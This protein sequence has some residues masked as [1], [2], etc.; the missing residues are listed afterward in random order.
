MRFRHALLL[1]LFILLVDQ[2]LK[3]YIKTHYFLGQEHLITNWF[4]LH[5][6]ENEGMAYGWKLGGEWGKLAL[7]LFRLVAV[8]FGTFY[9]RYIIRRSYHF[10]FVICATLIYA[11]AIGNLID[12]LFYG[13][14]F[15]NSDPF[16]QNVAHSFMDKGFTGGYAGFLHGKVVD[17]LY[18][19]IITD[20]TIPKW[21][22]V[23]GGE[24]F[25]FFRP[26]FNIADASISIGV[27]TILLFQKRFFSPKDEELP[28]T[29]ETNSTVNDEVQIS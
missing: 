19:P 28:T 25:E 10:G 5:F 24:P 9:I 1:T 14:I 27:L 6:I 3:V 22:P 11:G 8:I 16:T 13:L 20:A 2:I 18:F 29:V 21:V 12:S 26:V 4:R 17:M 15:E 23:W 7:T